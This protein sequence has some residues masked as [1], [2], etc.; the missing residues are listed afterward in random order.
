MIQNSVLDRFG[1]SPSERG[2]VIGF[3][4]RGFEPVLSYIQEEGSS[5]R[6]VDLDRAHWWFGSHIHC[7]GKMEE[8]KHVPCP[9]REPVDV[10]RVCQ[11]CAAPRIPNLE[12]VFDPM[13]GCTCQFCARDHVVYIAFYGDRVKVGMTSAARVPERLIEQGADAFIVASKLPSRYHARELEIRLSRDIGIPQSV[14]DRSHLSLLGKKTGPEFI[15]W[16]SDDIGKVLKDDMGLE[17]SEVTILDKYPMAQ[18]LR[19]TPR[20]RSSPGLHSGN[21]VGCKGKFLIYESGGLQALKLPD[22]EGREIGF[23]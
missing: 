22:L 6:T 7:I 23:L 19:R 1:E 10:H 14:S 5:P 9:N 11:A 17:P 18:P 13:P 16:R 2:F 8:G 4:W 21:V 3:G 20:A 12:H 15:K